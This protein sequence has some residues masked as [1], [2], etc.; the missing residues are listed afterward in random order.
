LAT[1]YAHAPIYALPA[2]YEPF[3]FSILEAAL[4][5]CALVLGDIPSLHESWEDAATFIPLSDHTALE[6]AI[7]DLIKYPARLNGFAA[8]AR[9]RALLMTSERMAEAYLVAYEE[10]LLPETHNFAARE[11]LA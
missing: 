8:R 6:Q 2:R 3:G 5:G 4:S 7:L 11:N 1:L 10:L 9:E